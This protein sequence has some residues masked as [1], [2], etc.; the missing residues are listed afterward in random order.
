[1]L[2]RVVYDD[3][4][5]RMLTVLMMKTFFP[6]GCG[7]YGGTGMGISRPKNRHTLSYSI[8]PENFQAY[9][10]HFVFQIDLQL[11]PERT[12]YIR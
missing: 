7:G 4:C 11:V 3:D 10:A 5:L 1:M 9:L 6:E 8:K 12:I 2:R